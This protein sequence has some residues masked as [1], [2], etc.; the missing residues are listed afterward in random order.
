MPNGLLDRQGR[1]RGPSV[2][3]GQKAEPPSAAID[4]QPDL[5]DQ[6]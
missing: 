6:A 5:E 4:D 2:M 3:L 1:P